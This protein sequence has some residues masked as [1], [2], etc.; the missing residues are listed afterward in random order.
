MQP[1]IAM[2]VAH[3]VVEECALQDAQ[4]VV[5]EVVVE[6]VKEAV[7][8]VVRE[9]V[10]ILVVDAA[11]SLVNLSPHLVLLINARCGDKISSV[12]I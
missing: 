7:Q 11:G 5:V 9:L 12:I 2:V 4:I 6:A 8:V 3:G 1:L 10:L